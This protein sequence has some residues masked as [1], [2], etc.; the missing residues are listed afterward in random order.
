MNEIPELIQKRLI[1]TNHVEHAAIF[2]RQDSSL[3]VASLGFNLSS[4][5]ITYL[6]S[7]FEDLPRCREDGVIFGGVTY[8]AIR[9]DKFS[10]YLVNKRDGL[11]L[12]KTKTLIIFTT[13]NNTQYASVCI[14]SAEN[15]GSY[16]KEK[17][18]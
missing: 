5:D 6:V 11:V 8:R 9:A 12:V 2:R 17:G 18:K 14:E 1:D 15:L 10:I 4:D 13:W 16:F 7:L 3:R